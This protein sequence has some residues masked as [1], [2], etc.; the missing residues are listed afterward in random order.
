LNLGDSI[1]HGTKWL[2]TGNLAKRFLEFLIGIVL[3]RILVP[4][5]F[6][7]VVTIQIFTGLAG[8]ISG[9]GM[10]QALIQAKA[11]Q[12]KDFEVVFTIQ[13][14]ICILIYALFYFIS[15]YFAQWFDQPIYENLL[16][17]SALTFLIRPFNNIPRSR[18]QREMKFKVIAIVEVLNIIFTGA[19]SIYLALRGYAVWALILGGLIGAVFTVIVLTIASPWRPRLTYDRVIAEKLG[20]YGIKSSANEIIFYINKQATNLIVGRLYGAG[21]LGLFNKAESLSALPVTIIAGS[22]YQTVFRALSKIQDNIDQSKYVYLRTVTL[23]SVYTMPFY[24]GLW[25]LAEPFVGIVYGEKWLPAGIL[26]K[27]LAVT[28]IFKCVMN[29][30]GAVAAAQNRLG[31]EMRIH[32]ETLVL[33]VSLVFLAAYFIGIDVFGVAVI[34]VISKVYLAFRMVSLAK[35]ILMV[36]W[37]EVFRTVMP[38]IYLSVLMYLSMLAT[39]YSIGHWSAENIYIYFFVMASV[40]ALVYGI[41]FLCCPIKQLESESKRWKGKLGFGRFCT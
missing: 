7:L 31:T 41:G 27:V 11:V 38:S 19:I 40:G 5:D 33:L 30:S 25:W 9:G 3:A 28:G 10:G 39:W 8:Y 36:S 34:F 21:A 18:L 32:L 22:A 14:F 20:S 24:V 12:A 15:P 35:N 1:R 26:L 16:R 29:P 23:V 13:L 17:V 6:G 37:M 4:E 2:F